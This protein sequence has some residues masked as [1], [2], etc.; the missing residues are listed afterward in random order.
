MLK[1]QHYKDHKFEG[2]CSE[3]DEIGKILKSGNCVNGKWDDV[4]EKVTIRKMV[5]IEKSVHIFDYKVYE[6]IMI[7]N[8]FLRDRVFYNQF[9]K[10][11]F[12]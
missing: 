2:L 1:S 4:G 12:V 6:I 5:V 7:K 9:V 3:Y 8:L 10:D 11:Q